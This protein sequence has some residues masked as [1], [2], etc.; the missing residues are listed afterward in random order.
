[1]II[2]IQGLDPAESLEQ[3]MGFQEHMLYF[4]CIQ[5]SHRPSHPSSSIALL[6]ALAVTA[7]MGELI[8]RNN[9]FRTTKYKSLLK[10][11]LL[12]WKA[13]LSKYTNKTKV[14]DIQEYQ[15]MIDSSTWCNT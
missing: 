5:D 9:V 1:M 15:S 8:D 14:C 7:T 12:C 11:G 3:Q 2:S 4:N 10:S 13:S 6:T